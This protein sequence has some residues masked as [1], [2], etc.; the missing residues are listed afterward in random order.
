MRRKRLLIAGGGFADI[1]MI[2][3]AR[4]LGF[5]VITSGNR[6][7]DLGH[8][9]SD[10]CHLEDFS[11]RQAMLRL[12]RALGI[13]AICASCNDFSA[14]TA[15]YVAENLGLPG[16]DS[17]EIALVLHEKDR[18]REFSRRI[19]IPAPRAES[20][21]SLIDAS[22]T[23]VPF[24]VIVKPVDLTGGKGISVAGNRDE[25][26][27]ALALAF[28]RTRAGR[29]VVE[30][31]LGG[32][33]HAL[34][35]FIRKRKV[36]FQFSDNEYYFRN[37]YL[38][39]AASTPGDVP[40]A[41]VRDLCSNIEHIADLLELRDGIFHVQFMLTD[42]G[43]VIIEVCRRPPGD[44]YTRLVEMATGVAYPEFIVRAAAGMTC[45]AIAATDPIG[46]FTRHCVMPARNG[47]VVTVEVDDSISD[48]VVEQMMWWQV[49]DLVEDYLTHKL[50]IAFIQF[51]SH[52]EMDELTR[53]M[54]D[55]IRTEVE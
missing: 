33:R 2:Q 17:L 8:R 10:E 20:F 32:S 23:S 34:S 11:D 24:P 13:D 14:L 12:A 9:H 7:E 16:H 52:A 39:S 27:A 36:V 26:S 46:Y 45:D 22:G 43:P 25:L 42:S 4:R 3:A 50:G 5:H 18:F 38:V 21:G 35:A 6:P 47:R 37:P 15:A 51:A 41:A 19:G 31:F 54:P 49:G 53:N 29:V 1:P 30:E 44:L 48:K 28:A 40:P 55:L